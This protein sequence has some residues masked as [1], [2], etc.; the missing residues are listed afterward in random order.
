[1]TL[2]VV[3]EAQMRCSCGLAPAALNVPPAGVA[4]QGAPVATVQNFI[5]MVNIPPFG[6]C[7]SSSNPEV[8]AAEDAPQPCVPVTQPWS[9]GAAKLQMSGLQPL[10]MDSKCNCQW[11]GE[12]SFIDAGQAA[13]QTG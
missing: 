9:Q 10:T 4:G 11:G 8:A 3:S 1:M 7:T 13:V 5:P 2:L 6:M 12:I